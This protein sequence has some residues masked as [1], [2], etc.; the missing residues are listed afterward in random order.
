MEKVNKM[1]LLKWRAGHSTPLNQVVF[2]SE[3]STWTALDETMAVQS[4]V[5]AVDEDFCLRRGFNRLDEDEEKDT[6][7][8]NANAK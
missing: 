5:K 3:T 4:Y 1:A 6:Y 8:S 7:S 2:C